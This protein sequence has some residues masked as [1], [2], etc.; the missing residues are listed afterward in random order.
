MSKKLTKEQI[1][2]YIKGGGHRCPHCGHEHLDSQGIKWD[3]DDNA[4]DEIHCL[5]CGEKWKDRLAI[6]G[7]EPV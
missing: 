4:F 7:V 1:E 5:Y 3:A 2:K 6:V